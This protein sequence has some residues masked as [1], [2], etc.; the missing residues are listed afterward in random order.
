MAAVLLV[1]LDRFRKLLGLSRSVPEI[2]ANV[3]KAMDE[4]VPHVIG[5]LES[6]KIA[7]QRE[8]DAGRLA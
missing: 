4:Y 1:G 8:H 2:E 7:V 5:P 3:T 6:N